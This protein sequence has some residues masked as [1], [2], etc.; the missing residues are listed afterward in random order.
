MAIAWQHR[1]IKASLSNA[2]CI[3]GRP[4]KLDTIEPCKNLD[5]VSTQIRH[6]SRSAK[7]L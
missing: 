4:I 3:M 6:E 1:P 5:L 7:L 2:A